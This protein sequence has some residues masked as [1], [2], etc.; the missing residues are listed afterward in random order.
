MACYVN[1]L[2]YL[3]RTKKQLKTKYL[4]TCYLSFIDRAEGK[5]RQ[6]SFVIG[7]LLK[8]LDIPPKCVTPYYVLYKTSKYEK[9]SSIINGKLALSISSS[10]S[11]FT[12]F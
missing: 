10:T 5:F 4:I 6:N 11:S 3:N 1:V 2:R 12:L 7:Y 8:L 9:T